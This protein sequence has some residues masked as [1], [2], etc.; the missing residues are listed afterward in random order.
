MIPRCVTT[1]SASSGTSLMTYSGRENNQLFIAA[2]KVDVQKDAPP[3][4]LPPSE[5]TRT[6]S[7]SFAPH[8]RLLA[9]G[10]QQPGLVRVLHVLE[11][12]EDGTPVLTPAWLSSTAD[13]HP[14]AV[15]SLAW[16]AHADCAVLAS[17]SGTSEA[18]S[19]IKLWNERGALLAELRSYGQ[20]N[21]LGWTA[22]HMLISGSSTAVRVW[23][24][25]F[26]LL[27]VDRAAESQQ[28]PART[29]TTTVGAVSSTRAA[30][31][32]GR[33]QLQLPLRVS[34]A[35]DDIGAGIHILQLEP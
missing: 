18:N 23:R 22:T 31:G 34:F 24:G 1:T 3:L 4:E 6:S 12:T 16:S 15:T 14:T 32:S 10:H 29:A 30:A 33:T 20:L 35:C 17:G 21:A 26:D 2:Y 7:V 5:G 13:A 25:L 11:C 28:A 9:V 27:P 8:R 19:V